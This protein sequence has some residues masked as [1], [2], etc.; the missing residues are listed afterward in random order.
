[1]IQQTVDL[2]HGTN[3]AC[4]DLPGPCRY[5]A[6]RYR[7]DHVNGWRKKRPRVAGE[8]CSLKVAQEGPLTLLQVARII[9]LRHERVRQIEAKALAK[10]RKAAP[11]LEDAFAAIQNAPDGF[12]YPAPLNL[13]R[14]CRDPR[15]TPCKW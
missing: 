2:Y 10:I 4:L 3:G 11:A 9:E 12:A 5:R 15:I 1:M 8:K 6:C 7:L 13:P 14:R